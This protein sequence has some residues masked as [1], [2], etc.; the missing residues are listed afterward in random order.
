[1]DDIDSLIELTNKTSLFDIDVYSF[2][3]RHCAIVHTIHN[4]A[5]GFMDLNEDIINEIDKC[6]NDYKKIFEKFILEIPLNIHSNTYSQK[7]LVFIKNNIYLWNTYKDLIYAYN[8]LNM[9]S[10]LI[11][12]HY[13]HNEIDYIEEV[14]YHN[15]LC[16]DFNSILFCNK[17]I[18]REFMDKV[19]TVFIYYLNLITTILNNQL[20][21]QFILNKDRLLFLQNQ[22][23]KWLKN[24]QLIY[25]YNVFNNIGEILYEGNSEIT[26]IKKI[27][28]SYFRIDE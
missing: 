4:I 5:Y 6:F 23:E 8:I 25:V 15:N 14:P 7:V 22:I 11:N 26:Y 3:K 2:S 1:M 9:T 10:Y 17:T 16:I 19:D 28:L 24:K 20:N 21:N 12:Y 27:D 18:S 13:D